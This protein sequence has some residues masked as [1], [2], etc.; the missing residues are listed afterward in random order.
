MKK[1]TLHS[2]LEAGVGGERPGLEGYARGLE[3]QGK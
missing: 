1:T 2:P 3:G